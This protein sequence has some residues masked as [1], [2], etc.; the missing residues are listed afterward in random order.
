ME[1][2]QVVNQGL[3]SSSHLE[4][5]APGF[6]CVVSTRGAQWECAGTAASVQTL[7]PSLHCSPC[8]PHFVALGV[9]EGLSDFYL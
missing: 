2:G 9:G 6:S 1:K 8:Q 7:L 3:F 5:F 4:E